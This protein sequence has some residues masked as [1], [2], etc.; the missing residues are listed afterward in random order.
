MEKFT[1]NSQLAFLTDLISGKSI[2][3]YYIDYLKPYK[4]VEEQDAKKK[5]DKIAFAAML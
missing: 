4:V 2:G 5:A 3:R 1:R